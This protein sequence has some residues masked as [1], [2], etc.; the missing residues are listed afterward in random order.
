MIQT[1]GVHATR[2]H[3][4]VIMAHGKAFTRFHRFLAKRKR[5]LLRMF[6]DNDMPRDVL[7]EKFK[8]RK[9]ELYGT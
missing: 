5:R 4:E 7:Q 2:T 1:G 3:K 8:R 6:L 9:I